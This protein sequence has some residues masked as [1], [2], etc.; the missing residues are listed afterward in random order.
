MQHW[1][2]IIVL[3]PSSAMHAVATKKGLWK[4]SSVGLEE[5]YLFWYASNEYSV[6]VAMAGR[7]VTIH[8][9]T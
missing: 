5:I 1:P 8:N 7:S 3:I 6:P 9:N 2:H 4:T